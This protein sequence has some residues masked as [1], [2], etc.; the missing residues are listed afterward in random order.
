MDQLEQSYFIEKY[1][2]YR[3]K[4]SAENLSLIECPI[5]SVNNKQLGHGQCIPDAI[6][7]KNDSCQWIELTTF[8]RN[9]LMARRIRE[10][11]KYP[12]H[13]EGQRIILG[14]PPREFDSLIVGFHE[15][16]RKK[17]SK[18]YSR[19]AHLSNTNLQGTLLVIFVNEDHFFDEIEYYQFINAV[20]DE[21][22][23]FSWGVA[24]GQ[25]DQII[26]GANVLINGQWVSTF[27]PIVNREKMVHLR[28]RQQIKENMLLNLAKQTIEIN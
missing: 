28:K 4:F 23:L 9:Q 20:K 16:I 10:M 17:V 26:L 14:I 6:V 25:F 1:I 19:F 11:I 12:E 8:S 27:E 5:I 22:I 3:D 18:D 24:T 15:A 21:H 2:E 13:F 7:N